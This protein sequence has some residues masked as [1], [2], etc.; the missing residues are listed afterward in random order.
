VK[1][2]M[3]SLFTALRLAPLVMKPPAD[4]VGGAFQHNLGAGLIRDRLHHAGSVGV[5]RRP[6]RHL[7]AVQ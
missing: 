1:I 6:E 7:R 5:A 3:N 2:E 4:A